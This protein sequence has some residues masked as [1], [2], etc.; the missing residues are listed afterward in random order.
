LER[1]IT[2]QE[3]LMA[4]GPEDETNLRVLQ[5]GLQPLQFPIVRD[6]T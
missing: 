2:N 5:L 3:I 4:E 6:V 1:I